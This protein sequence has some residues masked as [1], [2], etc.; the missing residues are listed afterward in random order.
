M[1]IT[2]INL[3]LHATGTWASTRKEIKTRN[4][5]DNVRQMRVN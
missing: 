2:N 4:G 5:I 1:L 3:K